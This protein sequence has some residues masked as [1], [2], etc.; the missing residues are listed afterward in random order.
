MIVRLKLIDV[1][2]NLLDLTASPF[3]CFFSFFIHDRLF[4]G[5]G[6]AEVAAKA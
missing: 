4:C 6:C 5:P 1:K 3:Y 2:T